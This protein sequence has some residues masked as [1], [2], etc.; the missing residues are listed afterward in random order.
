MKN[1]AEFK[2]VLQT[3]GVKLETLSLANGLAGGR[4]F[5]GQ[6]RRVNKADTTGVYL[7]DET[8]TGRGSFLGYGKASEW[9]FSE[10]IATN[11]YGLSYRVIL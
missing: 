2:R 9:E 6:I 3:P 4:L 8:T 11:S 7:S 5:V 1:L 10:D